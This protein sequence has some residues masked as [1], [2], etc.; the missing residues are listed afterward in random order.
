MPFLGSTV[1]RGVLMQKQFMV[2]RQGTTKWLDVPSPSRT[3]QWGMVAP[4]EQVRRAGQLQSERPHW[5][6]AA[7]TQEHPALPVACLCCWER[8][9]VLCA[10]KPHIARALGLQKP[11]EEHAASHST[12]LLHAREACS[13]CG[14]QCG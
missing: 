3:G 12:S 13:A 11:R 5:N 6:S 8:A 1:A 14:R 4:S 7:R 10:L 2:N 9:G